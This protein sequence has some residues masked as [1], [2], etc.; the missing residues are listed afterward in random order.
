MKKWV[1]RI[2]YFFGSILVLLLLIILLLQ[3]SWAKNLIRKKLQAYISEKTKTEFIIG[4]VD[5]SLPKWVELNGVFMR[6]LAKDTLLYGKQLKVDI[7]MFKLIG[8]NVQI[9]K[10]AFDDVYINLTKKEHET[11]FNYQFIVDAFKSK[12][13]DK[14]DEEGKSSM[15]LSI[16][17]I[18]LKNTRFN[19]LDYEEGSFM[20]LYAG[21]FHLQVDSLDLEKMHFDIN[22]LY[23]D[24]V[25]FSMQLTKLPPDTAKTTS[26]G[27]SLPI[28]RADSL[29]IKNSN[30]LFENKPEQ[31]YT[32]NHIGL[33]QAANINNSKQSNTFTGKS[34]MLAK[35]N[36]AFRHS[37][38]EQAVTTKKDTLSVAVSKSSSLNFVMEELSLL[39]NNIVYDNTAKPEK[40]DGLDYFHLGI[41]DLNFVAKAA[42]F[43]D[44][45]IKSRIERFSFK[46][47]SGFQLDSLSGD[48]SVDTSVIS[49][50]NFVLR[51]P[52]S[53]INVT[54]AV[55]PASFTKPIKGQGKLPDN[56]I[57][58]TKTIIGKKDL[59]L[60]AE[61]L[62]EK[63]KQQ[64]DELGNLVVDAHIKG[65]ADKLY[66]QQLVV[67]A[68]RPNKLNLQMSGEVYNATNA[69][70]IRYNTNIQNLSVSEKL[71]SP[72]LKDSKQKINLPPI[73]NIKG[74]VAGDTRNVNANIATNSSY[75]FAAI[76]AKVGQFTKPA[77]M[78]YDIAVN[79]KNFETGKWIGQDSILGKLN[80]NIAVKGSGGFDVKNN[81]MKVVAAIKSFGFRENTIDNINANTSFNKGL[82]QGTASVKDELVGISFNGKAN[83][84]NEYPT[85]D[86]SVNISNADLLALGFSKDTMNIAAITK[87]KVENSTPQNLNAII[88]I[89][90][91]VIKKDQQKIIMDSATVIAFVRNDSTII[92]VVSPF[93]D[94]NVK[95]TVYYN[96]IPALLQ[97]VMNQF[98][99]QTTA[100]VN[101]AEKN[102]TA[103]PGTVQANIVIKPNETYNAFVKNVSFDEAIVMNANI[104]NKNQDSAVNVKLDVPGL[105]VG[106]SR[107]GKMQGII[108][109]KDDSLKV[110]IGI[111][112]VK[113][114]N[115][116][117][118]DATVIGGFSKNSMGA[119][120]STKDE[121]KKEQFKLTVAAKPNDVEGYDVTLGKDLLL[122][123]QTWAVN[124]QNVVRTS[125]EGF[126]IQ[127]FDISKDNQKIAIHNETASATSPIIIAIDNFK[128]STVTAALNKDSAQIEGLLNAD[129]K[130]SDLNN[131]IPTMDGTV[132]LD[133]LTYQNMNVGNLD[134]K[135]Q[136]ANN[137]VTVSGKLLGNGN[138]V[139]LSGSY[140]ANVIDVKI[141]MNPISASSI[142]PFTKGN[143]VRSSGTITGPITIT[144]SAS[145]PEWNG[146]LTFN[147]VK[148]TAAKFGTYMSIDKQSIAFQYPNIELNEF[149]IKDSTGNSLELNGSLVQ[150]KKKG[151][152][153]DL[154]VIANGFHAMNNTAIDNN[155]LYGKAIV[156]VDATI[157]GPVTAPEIGGNVSIKNGTAVTFIR[158]N[159]PP[160]AKDREGVMEFIDMDTVTNL[161]TKITYEEILALQDEE[162]SGGSLNYNLNLEVEPEAKFNV[163]VD[164]ITRDELEVQ[165]QAQINVGVNPNGSIAL[166]GTYN[167]KKGYYQLNYQFIK[168]KFVLLDGS[169]IT[170][171]G[172]P[173][174]AYA[175]ITAAYEISTPAL[176]LVGN[177]ISGTGAA[178]NSIY[179]R[180]VPFQ[181]LLKI[182]GEVT[183]P[184][185]SFDIVMKDRAEGVSYEMANTIDNKLQQ[186]R[187][188]PSAMNKQVFSLLVLNRFIGEQSRDFFAGNGNANSSILANES[189]SGFLNGAINQIAADLVK[190]I[191]IDINLKNVDDDP[192]A[193]RTDL[194]VALSKNFLDDRLNVSVGKSFTV[195]GSDPSANSRNSSNNNV[196]FIPD[197][198]STYKLSK[199]GKYMIRAYRRNQYEAL[200]DGYFIETGVAFTFTVD[201][202]KLRELFRKNKK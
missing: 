29:I 84:H 152:I 147:N 47:K 146:E 116:L 103:R 138:N 168:R 91:A 199:D 14:K 62:T 16:K 107:V 4:S 63:Y 120:L 115:I 85:A 179:K 112:T 23:A 134:L 182:K 165:G 178:E 66:I 124:E 21:D 139:D 126:N 167:L 9:D 79:A 26:S 44:G 110:N 185:L 176:D 96:E 155:M 73:I 98:M 175:D 95:S 140:N 113:T 35:S 41:K 37:T 82:I 7:A 49:V 119:T 76:K 93:A 45:N 125:N 86:A 106:T 10:I 122:N 166:A 42:A 72:F 114:G 89:D 65:N 70:N 164:P 43:V 161:L 80:G 34:F 132:K 142:E 157:I 108:L 193:V 130:V 163:I 197:V 150:D 94:A 177:E 162:A 71:I 156:D 145:N 31:L 101:N 202:N 169:T 8:G 187:T 160:S 149:A 83:I 28:L 99:P 128:L 2:L 19:N 194:S 13:N 100:S 104:T 171:S 88:R 191:D 48:V 60:L 54:A 158:Q 173:K 51:T 67:N 39:E 77:N 121:D 5:Y 52:S 189:V 1:K 68:T 32:N 78:N 20:R 117:L 184:Q 109:G 129:V 200:L 118:Y 30:I 6:D 69:K 183:K 151:F 135:A 15:G 137:N 102:K 24:N 17:E 180:K 153:S 148:A 181:V 55:Y 87:I 196:Q 33:M 170:L 75:G 74:T 111:D 22:K 141:N 201:Y 36:I 123:K 159:T 27:F 133:S 57:T 154:T 136:S 105:Q 3:T 61:G 12:T 174:N 172:D 131:A 64:L 186:L 25:N 81:N 195:E 59:E 190:G 11:V 56:D 198:N 38:K 40:K 46:D 188:D 90:S 97:Q 50:K 144:G 127:N 192:N 92:Q 18:F 53:S 58:I 143:I